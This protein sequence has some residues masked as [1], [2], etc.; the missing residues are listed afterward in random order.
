[1]E[2]F[3]IFRKLKISHLYMC[4]IIHF[5]NNFIKYDSFEYLFNYTLKLL[6]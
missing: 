5:V 3:N 6:Y 4:F 2:I 1:M